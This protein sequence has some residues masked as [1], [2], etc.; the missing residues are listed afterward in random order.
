MLT[1]LFRPTFQNSE[2][3]MAILGLF[4]GNLVV[5]RAFRLLLILMFYVHFGYLRSIFHLWNG[6]GVAN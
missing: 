2:A 6:R 4:P 5:V 3:K 1:T